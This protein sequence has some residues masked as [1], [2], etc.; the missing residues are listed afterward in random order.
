MWPSPIASTLP[1]AL[2]TYH[3]SNKPNKSK[4]SSWTIITAM[5]ITI[6]IMHHHHHHNDSNNHEMMMIPKSIIII[7]PQRRRIRIIRII[8][9]RRIWND[10]Y[11]TSKRRFDNGTSTKAIVIFRPLVVIERMPVF[12]YG[13]HE[14]L[15][16]FGGASR[17]L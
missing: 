5:T 4:E 12:R 7:I 13:M 3:S 16:M 9:V 6:I 17:R 1:I 14:S 2:G 11:E 8:R 15:G 10:W